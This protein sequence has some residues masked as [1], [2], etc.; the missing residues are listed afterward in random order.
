MYPSDAAAGADRTPACKN[1][2][3][4]PPS[5]APPRTTG[6]RTRS[7]AAR[8]D[9]R[10]PQV[11]LPVDVP[12][13]LG[14][15]AHGA[16]AQLHHRRRAGA[17]HAHAGLQRAAAHGLGR[18]RPAGRER[19]HGQR[20][21]AGEVDARQHRLHEARSCSRWASRIDWSRELATCDPSYYRWN[22]WLFLRMLEQG[23]AY[24][25]TGVVNWD[26]V[27]Q[28]VLAN[29][30]V[31]DGRGWR[32]GALVEKREI[33]MYYLRITRYAE[34]LL[35]A[36]DE[37]A[38]TGPSACAPCRPTGSAAAR[39]CEIDF[40]VRRRHARGARCGRDAARC[41]VFTTRADTLFGAT[42]MAVVGRASA[43]AGRRAARR[44]GSRPS[45]TSAGAAAPWKP[46]SPRRR[47]TA[48][49]PGCTCCI[50][51][52]ASAAG[53]GRQLRADGLRRRRGDGR[54]GAR[55]A[56]LRVRAEATA[57]PMRTVVR[58]ASGA[59]RRP[60]ARRGS[61]PM[62]STA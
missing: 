16:C 13:P 6:T 50:R 62:P 34:E 14:P 22:Q 5:S 15:A 29:E 32:T 28:T 36:L 55:R 7:F 10:A 58:S 24:K 1:A 21:A 27:D 53:L 48:C 59:L 12:V 2:T 49:P 40:P 47:S 56:R 4:P 37:P 60:S 19:R 33:P 41:K 45:S 9:A 44:R 51:S 39:A 57:L 8:E 31:I 17:L 35:A 20:R 3:I 26:P 46:T 30:Q 43:G 52:P 18:L 25:K 23:I 11:L 42:F 38:P 61:E 54:A